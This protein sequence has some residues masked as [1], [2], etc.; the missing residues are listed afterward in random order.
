MMFRSHTQPGIASV[1][2]TLILV[3]LFAFG[4][5][6]QGLTA[7]SLW[8][9]EVDA[10][11]FALR[12]LPTTLAMFVQAGQ[13][14]PLYFLALRPWF[15][16]VGAS[17]YALRFPSAA[18]GA[19]AIPLLW[20]VA[21]MLVSPRAGAEDAGE[22]AQHP[23]AQAAVPLL[24]VLLFAV[25][26]YQLWYGQEG[27]MYTLVTALVLLATW[28]WLRGVQ[29]GGWRP[30]LGYLA[31]VS[32]AMYS[33]LLMIML[34]PLHLLW[35]VIAWP[36]SRRH[37]RGYGLAL[38]GLTLPYLPMVW[39]QWDLLMA[40][41]RRTGFN[42]TP[43]APMLRTLLFNHSRGFLPN[44]D[45]LVLTPIFFLGLAGLLLGLGELAP[46]S[47]DGKT[48]Q[49]APWRRFLLVLSWLT[50]PVAEIYA[51]SLRQPI[52]TDR[53]V[54]WIAPAAMILLALGAAVLHRNA[55]R[56]A[57]PLVALVVAYVCTF[58]LYVGWQQKTMPM[59]YDLRS[60]VSYVAER[61]SAETLLILQIPHM[62]WSYRYYSSD[63]AADLFAR[64]DAQLGHWAPGLWTNYGAPDDQARAEV[65]QQM[66][67]I[68][69]G[70]PEIWVFRSEVE[71]WD[72]RHLMDAWL[73]QHGELVEQAH[74]HGVQVRRYVML[75][76]E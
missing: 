70:A 50:L 58:W 75:N 8:R 34:I 59:K 11:Y 72:S 53:Y 42:F 6:I 64:S 36:Q 18:L 3:T 46:P 7:Q 60:A 5:R 68:T 48:L 21:R 28:L 23:L 16:L 47:S 31:T 54:I 13:N 37:W 76:G 51:L 57:T 63:F 17:E 67:R 30:W 14:G 2:F 29:S 38:A 22:G 1:R 44:D 24:A 61:R 66:R 43:L 4:W 39:W 15:Y 73:D 9:D 52:F 49:L 41:D 33:H 55:G 65:D 56:I 26:P 19:L 20:Q 32:I 74:F 71:M 62:E 35:Y 69:A 40:A 25:N 45:L 27:K 12:E 10:I